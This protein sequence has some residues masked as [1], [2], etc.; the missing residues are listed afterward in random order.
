M[1]RVTAA[2][3]IAA[4]LVMAGNAHSQTPWFDPPAAAIDLSAAV[5]DPRVKQ[6]YDLRGGREAWSGGRAE[7][8]VEAIGQAERHGLDPRRFLASIE[9]ASSPA[10]REAALTLAAITYGEALAR[11]VADPAKL[12]GIYTLERPRAN[13][14]AD[15][16]RAVD[17][18]DLRDWF[19][20]LAPQDAEYRALSDA[21]MRSRGRV[22]TTSER[23]IPAG[24]LIREG[25]QDPRVPAGMSRS[26]VAPTRPRLRR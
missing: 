2:T 9:A 26:L 20:R 16:A 21:Y 5:S 14:A 12:H 15:L 23:D 17:A 24:G 6:F 11:G 10:E 4:C 22:G 19:E 25:S 3:A 1:V 13:V 7:A 18:G 8:L